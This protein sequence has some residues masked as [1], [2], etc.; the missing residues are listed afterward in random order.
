MGVSAGVCP[1]LR[2]IVLRLMAVRSSSQIYL[3]EVTVALPRTEAGAAVAIAF[4]CSDM[5]QMHGC[6]M[7]QVS[8]AHDSLSSIDGPLKPFRA[9][10]GPQASRVPL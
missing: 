4:F 3:K 2:D 7:L 10:C 5:A 8:C 6:R 9:V 1:S